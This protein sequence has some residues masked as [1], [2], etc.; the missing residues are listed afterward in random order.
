MHPAKRAYQSP[1]TPVRTPR[2]VEY[3]LLARITQRLAKAWARRAEDYPAFVAALSENTRLWST[4]AADLVDP[5]NRL[6]E[7][8]RGQLF[9]LFR[10]TDEHSRAIL[11]N[12]GS[13]EVLIDINKAVM[14]GLRGPSENAGD[15]AAA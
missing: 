1:D 15:E 11:D 7:K 14:R 5:G 12:R 13:A 4:F 3:D 2:Q 6:P 9:Y 8:L 10:F